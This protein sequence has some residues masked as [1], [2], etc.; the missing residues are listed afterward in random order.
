VEKPEKEEKKEDDNFGFN[1]TPMVKSGRKEEGGMF[2]FDD[3]KKE[4]MKEE[5]ITV[6]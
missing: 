1:F 2:D 3:Q 4:E 6:V 5:S